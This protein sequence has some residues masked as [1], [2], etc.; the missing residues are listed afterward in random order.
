MSPSASLRGASIK[1]FTMVQKIST[2]DNNNN[3]NN[4]NSNNN[5]N[6]S[7]SRPHAGTY[8]SLRGTSG[9]STSTPNLIHHS[10]PVTPHTHHGGGSDI[11]S[12]S[13]HSSNNH[14]YASMNNNNNNNNRGA[15][16]SSLAQPK[17]TRFNNNNIVHNNSSNHHADASFNSPKESPVPSGQGV[18]NLAS[19]FQQPTTST[20]SSSSSLAPPVSSSLS[21]SNGNDSRS[22][23]A[24]RPMSPRSS[25][26]P[27]QNR[28]VTHSS[29]PLP[30]APQQPQHSQSSPA[31]TAPSN[32]VPARTPSPGP[33]Q[34]KAAPKLGT[35]PLPAV[36]KPGPK[37]VGGGG[38]STEHFNNNGSEGEQCCT[39]SGR[40]KFCSECGKA[41]PEN[42][43]LIALGGF[44]HSQ[45]CYYIYISFL[46]YLVSLSRC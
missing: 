14:G 42:Q 44:W 20:P 30:P 32:S 9:A 40:L 27:N 16:P 15:Q 45:A 24:A 10:T 46:P 43:G 5:N 3:S 38:G 22:L 18:S 23:G 12:N 21:T 29:S 6:N 19:K 2:V 17:A 37:V 1:R 31:L 41:V 26:G 25:W 39:A 13:N 11:A 36:P 34:S 7:A 28:H 4:N 35:K 33:T 8:S